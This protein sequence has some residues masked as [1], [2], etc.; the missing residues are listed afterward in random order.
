[1]NFKTPMYCDRCRLMTTSVD[2][3]QALASSTG[4]KHYT[5]LEMK[6]NAKRGCH[7]CDTII[8]ESPKSEKAWKSD[9][10]L[11]LFAAMHGQRLLE[12]VSDM[13]V[14]EYPCRPFDEIRGYTEDDK[15]KLTLHAFTP[16]GMSY[17]GLCCEG[18]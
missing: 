11:Y 18:G 5:K 15:Y 6:Q 4:Y 1:M 12:R 7:L 10:N 17:T 2:G 3:L 16:P 14:C 13:R 8:R 9:A